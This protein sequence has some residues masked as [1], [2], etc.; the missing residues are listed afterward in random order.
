MPQQSNFEQI[1]SKSVMDLFK[2]YSDLGTDDKLALLYYIYEKMGGSV[3]P[4]APEATD[5]NLAEPLIEELYGQSQE[6][7]LNTMR[8]IANGADTPQSHTYGGL[9]PNNQLLVWYVWAEE[10]GKRVVDMPGDY[11]PSDAVQQVLKQIEGLEF[12]EQISFLREAAS[13]MGYSQVK[14]T[15]TQAETGVTPSL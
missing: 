3:T 2:H 10:M 15:P 1:Q 6:D 11:A 8:A 7:Q 9:S 14:P 5:L 13:R 12:Q 4:A